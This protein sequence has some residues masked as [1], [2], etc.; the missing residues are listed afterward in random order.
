MMH[1]RWLLILLCLFGLPAAASN[2]GGDIPPALQPWQDWVLHDVQGWHCP[3]PPE[4]AEPVS[5]QWPGVLELE[6]DARGGRFSQRWQVYE[7]GPVPLPGGEGLWPQQ[8]RVDGKPVPVV[9]ASGHPAVHLPAGTH[10]IEG[11]F[12]WHALPGRLPL[13]PAIGL[14]RLRIDGHE[15]PAYRRDANGLLWLGPTRSRAARPEADRV[16]LQV[17]RRIDDRIPVRIETRI[18]LRVS[19]QPREARLPLV[20]PEGFTPYRLHSS[21]PARLEAD[22]QLR[23]QLRP[24]IWQITLLARSTG[25]VRTLALP[26]AT[27][28]WPQEELWSLDSGHYR[29][30]ELGG[31]ERVDPTQTELPPAWQKLPTRRMI[32]GKTRLELVELRRLSP[33]DRPDQLELRRSLWPDIHGSGW[34]VVDQMEGQL[35]RS[36]RLQQMPPLLLGRASANGRD[37]L[38]TRLP[39]E[40]AAGIE[41]REGK[42]ALMAVSRIEEDTAALPANGWNT[43]M[44]RVSAT[45]N[46]PPG[47]RLL[48]TRGTEPVSGAWLQRWTLLDL[49]LVLI[50]AVA[51]LR[52]FGPAWGL[53][54]LLALGLAWH[55]PGAPHYAWLHLLA[56]AGLARV[57][58]AGR[59]QWLARIWQWLALGILLL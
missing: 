57:L 23:L 12:Q 55:E 46:L 27:A 58:P 14:L 45:L 6:L 54:A 38:I 35:Q 34:T 48:A 20:L 47:W 25:P 8:V 13:S 42:L 18:H 26:A 3:H 16:F 2:T 50:T 40:P 32:P 37:R 5:C 41:L 4:R 59:L 28:P 24:G 44:D 49:F 17:F 21:L 52:L 31:G 9:P 19:G 56:A 22:G 1:A 30:A 29:E 53:V 10:R 43:R 11:R 7:S 36:W 15:V 39:E 51:C 33:E